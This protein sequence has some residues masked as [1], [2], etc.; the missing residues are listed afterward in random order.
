MKKLLL[1]GAL[2]LSLMG[3]SGCRTRAVVTTRPE[4]P[5]VVVRPAPPRPDYVWIEGDWYWSGGRYQWRPGY[6]A[7]PRGVWVQGHWVQRGH[8]WYWERGHW[9]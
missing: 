5:V 1:C 7:A 4:P 3:T 2:I 9:R 8:G 6:W